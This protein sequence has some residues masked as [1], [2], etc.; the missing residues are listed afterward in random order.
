MATTSRQLTT[1]RVVFRLGCSVTV[2]GVP[3][4][5]DVI[6]SSAFTCR[7]F[8]TF[9]AYDVPWAS[10]KAPS[11]LPCTC[12]C[13]DLRMVK[14]I[15]GKGPLT[16]VSLSTCNEPCMFSLSIYGGSVGPVWLLFN[17]RD[18][19]GG[20]SFHQGSPI[21][22]AGVA[23]T[24]ARLRRRESSYSHSMSTAENELNRGYRNFP[25]ALLYVCLPSLGRAD[26]KI[27]HLIRSAFCGSSAPLRSLYRD[28]IWRI[29][30]LDRTLFFRLVL[31]RSEKK[32]FTCVQHA[33]ML[34]W[35]TAPPMEVGMR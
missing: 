32:H 4:I 16:A 34:N 20:G 19:P 9:K 1:H 35:V 17:I 21:I 24:V 5:N 25:F 7:M 12:C 6:D 31:F 2:T 11:I 27:G 8:R 30:H 29:G 26:W 10:G 28:S 18:P 13:T 22:A 14:G 33:R 3:S 23:A 15:F